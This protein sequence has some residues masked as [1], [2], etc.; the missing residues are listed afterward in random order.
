DPTRRQ[1]LLT[2]KAAS[3]RKL[4]EERFAGAPSPD[5]KK[6]LDD[7]RDVAALPGDRVRGQAVF[8]K[9]CATCHALAQTGHAVGPDLVA[10]ANKTPQYLLQEILDPNRNVDSRYISYVAVTKSG[11]S[12]TGLLASETASSI[13]LRGPEGKQETILRADLDDLQSSGTSLMPV[14]LE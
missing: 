10:V 12:F 1:R 11:L 14:G 5:R 4:A 8:A 13:T 6:I 3:V 9:T 2:S 7:Y